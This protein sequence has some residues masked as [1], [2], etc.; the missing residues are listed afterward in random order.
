MTGPA[1]PGLHT[2]TWAYNIT[3][4]VVR[5]ALSPSEKRDSILRAVRAPLVLDSLAKAKY[6]SAALAQARV[7]LAPAPAGGL[8]A[9]FG[10][11]GGGGRGGAAAGCERPFTMW[12]PFCARP[13]EPT[14]VPG[15]PGRGAGGGGG[16]NSEG[17]QKIFA[18]IGI[19]I[20]GAG[21]ARGGGGFGG[22][23][24]G[25]TAVSGDYSVVLQV[26]G[27]TMKQ[28]LRLENTAAASAGGFGGGDEDRDRDG[29]DRRNR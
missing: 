14:P 17:V 11:G 3:R 20:P 15:G 19:P 22:F 12:D 25:G 8:A 5:G 10:G 28:R 26:N 4:P 16:A 2:V 24:G 9:A 1:T 6:D 23:G 18:L 7:L 27:V 29:D 13:A 21:G